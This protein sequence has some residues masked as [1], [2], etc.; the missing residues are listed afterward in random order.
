MEKENRK[1]HSND[2]VMVMSECK[3][4][5]MTGK[6]IKYVNYPEKYHRLYVLVELSNGK[7]HQYRE[8]NLMKI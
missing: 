7:I 4:S 6:V 8:E 3:T 2:K 1:F 5:G